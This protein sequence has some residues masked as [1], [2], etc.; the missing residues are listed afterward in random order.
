V[1][2]DPIATVGCMLDGDSR[3]GTCCYTLVTLLLCCCCWC[4]AVTLSECCPNAIR[5]LLPVVYLTVILERASNSSIYAFYVKFIYGY[6]S[7]H[8]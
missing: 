4:T 1:S 6:L 7:P 5:M 2:K 3:E 8:V